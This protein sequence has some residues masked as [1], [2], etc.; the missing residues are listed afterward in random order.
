VIVIVNTNPIAIGWAVGQDDT[1]GKRFFIRFGARI[2]T[3]RQRA[4]SQVKRE[5]LGALTTLKA[6]RNYLIGANVVLE[7]DCLPLLGM[8]ANCFIPDIIMLRWIA[9]I[10]SLNPVLVHIIVVKN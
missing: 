1:Y 2:L 4:Y 3:E 5:L 8:I 10:K 7:T 9:Y 6:E